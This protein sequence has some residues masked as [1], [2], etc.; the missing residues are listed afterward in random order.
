MRFIVCLLFLTISISTSA[1]AGDGFVT[2]LRAS[3]FSLIPAPQKVEMG[4]GNVSLTDT[5]VIDYP[6]SDIAVELLKQKAAE[7][8]GVEFAASGG[9]LIELR[10]KA[11]AVPGIENPELSSQAYKLEISAQAVRITANSKPGLLYGAMSFV[12]LVKRQS[13]GK[14]TLPACVITDWPE[15]QLRF[16]HWDTKHHQERIPTLKRYIDWLALFKVNA[17]GF[18]IEDKYEYPSHPIIGAPGAYTKAEMQDL[19]SYALER[20]I[21]LV[22]VVQAPAHMAYVLKHEEFAHLRSDNSNYQA[23]MCDPEAIKLIF[24]MYQDMIDATPGVKYF[25]VSTDE[26]YYAG[27]CDKCKKE[28]ND[29]NRSL[30]WVDYVNKVHEFMEKRGRRM[31]AWVEYPLLPKDVKLIPS[32]II[33]GIMSAGRDTEWVDATDQAGMEQLAYSSMQGAEYLFPNLFPTSYRGRHTSGRLVDASQSV[34]SIPKRANLIGTFAASWDDS[35]LAS[36]IFWLGWATVTQY[37]WTPGF[38]TVDQNVADFMD[39][40][41]GPDRPD[42]VEVY[43]TLQAGARFYED[44][45]DRVESKERGPGYGNSNGPGIGVTRHD[46]VLDVPQLPDVKTLAV[47]P[48]F[49]TKYKE[50]I[51]EA[52]ELEEDHSEMVY[53]LTRGLSQVDRNQYNLEVLLSIAYLETFGLHLPVALAG[54]EHYLMRAYESNQQGDASR[55]VASLVEAYK[56]S[57]KIIKKKDWMMTNLE[58]VWEKAR[59]EKCATVDGREFLHVLDD[60]KDHW[61]D[62]RKGI[63]YMIAPYQRMKLEQWHEELGKRIEAFATANNLPLEGMKEARLE[64]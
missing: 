2:D 17:I 18:E 58:T 40:F 60:V 61:A 19:T 16:V 57:G 6:G 44:L 10:V 52:G 33:N 22:P 59:F 11:G 4:S 34:V 27:I 13:N 38:P 14:L 62:R 5:W 48:V 47:E 45:W 1:F 50:K 56:L 26:V 29:E 64:D 24:D 7:F 30:A 32:D 28:F 23:C 25:H 3:G 49:S 20:H 55:A 15:L 31:L 36:E 21:Q 42:M 8:H 9:S 51:Q 35:G 37:G 53:Q 46:Q 43:K 39:V 12:Q 54:V 41:Y 63:D